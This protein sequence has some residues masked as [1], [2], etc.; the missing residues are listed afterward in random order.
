MDND[1]TG[2]AAPRQ[3]PRDLGGDS[4]GA[5]EGS[6][7]MHH[8]SWTAPGTF[9]FAYKGQHCFVTQ[10]G[11]GAC[12]WISGTLTYFS[13]FNLI[14]TGTRRLVFLFRNRNESQNLQQKKSPHSVI[15][16]RKIF[17]NEIIFFYQFFF[18]TYIFYT[19]NSFYC[20]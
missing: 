17:F 14:F 4:S 9:T 15:K 8:L 20:K 13:S 16:C 1:H 7:Q 18:I 2:S 19:N 12:G 6:E 3:P 11:Q 5:E 10:Q